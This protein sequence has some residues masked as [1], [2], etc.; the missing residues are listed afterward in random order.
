MT[1]MQPQFDLITLGETMLRL[2]PP[3]GLRL[4]QSST[5]DMQFGGAESN[6]A[7]NL[8]RLGRRVSWWSRLP[9]SPLGRQLAASLR[10][11]GVDTSH[12]LWTENDRLGLYFVEQGEP[13][14]GVQVWY[15]RAHSAASQ[16]QPEHVADA[17]LASARWLHLTGITPALSEACRATVEAV[18]R[19]A[20]AK[21]LRIS[22]D[23]NYRALL[24]S[25]EAAAAVLS[26]LCAAADIAFV[27]LRDAHTLFAAQGDR[28]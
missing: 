1:D 7:A 19:R 26:P 18:L 4:G 23:V 10:G 2:M 28:A 6:V 12:V 9:D 13:P 14:R 17:W 11:Q 15:D 27:A 25:A 21:G 8:A 3:H 20:R 22:F 24:W 16:M 5:L